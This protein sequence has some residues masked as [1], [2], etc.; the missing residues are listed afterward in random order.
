[1]PGVLPPCRKFRT[2]VL[3]QPLVN[4]P[5]I[6]CGKILKLALL[7]FDKGQSFGGHRRSFIDIARTA[8][9]HGLASHVFELCTHIGIDIASSESV[10][11]F[12]HVVLAL[13][14]EGQ[15]GHPDNNQYYCCNSAHDFFPSIA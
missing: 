9:L 15:A 7:F 13:I 6:G 1:M 11:D 8:Q 12:R 2:V 3:Q 10:V 5:P 14:G 4:R